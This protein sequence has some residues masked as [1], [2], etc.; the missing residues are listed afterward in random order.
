[1]TQLA[2][3]K[4]LIREGQILYEIKAKIEFQKKG[5]RNGRIC[6]PYGPRSH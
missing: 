6:N 4:K 1:M 2:L 3:I 5:K